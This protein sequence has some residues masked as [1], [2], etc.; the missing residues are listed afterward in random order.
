MKRRD[1]TRI[2][3]LGALSIHALPATASAD[4]LSGNSE[5][6]IALGIGNHSLRAW[7]PNAMELIDFAVEHRLD[8]VQFNNLKPFKSLDKNHLARI[9]EHAMAH[10]ISIF[11]GVGGICEKSNTFNDSFGN[12][13]TL[14]KKGIQVARTLGSPVLGVR[15]GVLDDRYYGGGIK[16]KMEQVITLMQSFRNLMLNSGIK[17]AFENHAGDMRSEELLDL[18]EKTGSDICGALFDP[19]NAIYAMEDP[20]IAMKAIGKHIL[21]CSAR[22]VLVWQTDEGAVFQWTAIG[23]GMMDFE[24]YVTFLGEHCPGVP[25]HLEIIS[26]SPRSIPYLTKD[27]WKGWPDLKASGIIDFLNM[28]RLGHPI[29]VAKRPE[30]MEK[31]KFEMENQREELLRSVNYLREK[32]G[33]GLK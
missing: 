28:A 23:E 4:I 27:Y 9:K 17:F 15:I 5:P 20:L 16:P 3:G 12:A 2:A 13:A 21:C 11:V 26:N 25:L 19:G 6:N 18:I 22:D 1:F 30:G 7:R 31:K 29:K 32:C 10:D 33:A 8:S 24:A 14:V